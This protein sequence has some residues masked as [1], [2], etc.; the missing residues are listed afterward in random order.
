MGLGT[1]GMDKKCA[2]LEI[3]HLLRFMSREIMN[4]AL[5]KGQ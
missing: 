3:L 5:I 4:A 1:L 2:Q